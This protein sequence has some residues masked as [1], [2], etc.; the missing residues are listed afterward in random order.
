MFATIY[1]PNFFLQAAVRHQQIPPSTPVALID[2]QEKKP[3]ILQLNHSAEDVGV[4][5]GMAP[6]QALARCLDVI[7]KSRSPTQ[8][9]AAT[10]LALQYCFSL[11][12]YVEATAPGVWTL[13]FTRRDNL[14][15][16]ISDVVND[17]ARCELTAQ[18][19]IAATPDMSFLAANLARSVLG[20][21]NAEDFLAPLS[22]DI[23]GI[24]F[25]R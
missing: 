2:E 12:P 10:N 5:I 6:S 1:L 17:L 3:V 25:Q 20:I 19:G 16:K 18:A 14:T 4:R 21:D 24:P 9:A 23:L 22:I 11:T 15:R 8:E 13:Q 7:I